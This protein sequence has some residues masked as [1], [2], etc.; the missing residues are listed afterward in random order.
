MDRLDPGPPLT[1]HSISPHT[2]A[3]TSRLDAER[4]KGEGQLVVSTRQSLPLVPLERRQHDTERDALRDYKAIARLLDAPRAYDLTPDIV[5][6]P[7]THLTSAHQRYAAQPALSFFVAWVCDTTPE[8]G[9]RCIHPHRTLVRS[10]HPPGTTI[11]GT[12]PLSSSPDACSLALAGAAHP[13]CVQRL[14]AFP[15]FP[16]VPIA[17]RHTTIAFSRI[18]PSPL[19]ACASVHPQPAVRDDRR[20]QRPPRPFLLAGVPLVASAL[21]ATSSA[22]SHSKPASATQQN[23]TRSL[24]VV[25]S[26]CSPGCQSPASPSSPHRILRRSSWYSDPDAPRFRLSRTADPMRITS[27]VCTTCDNPSPSLALRSAP[28]PMLRPFSPLQAPSI[29]CAAPSICTP[30]PFSHRRRLSYPCPRDDRLRHPKLDHNSPTR[31]SVLSARAALAQRAA[32]GSEEGQC[33]RPQHEIAA[34]TRSGEI[35]RSGRCSHCGHGEIISS[36]CRTLIVHSRRV[37][38]A[39]VLTRTVLPLRH[40]VVLPALAVRTSSTPAA[41]HPT[42]ASPTRH[43]RTPPTPYPPRPSA[44]F[45]PFAPGYIQR[46][47]LHGALHGGVEEEVVGGGCEGPEGLA[48]AEGRD[49]LDAVLVAH[50]LAWLLAEPEH[51]AQRR[52][53][54][55]LIAVPVPM[56]CTSKLVENCFDVER[57]RPPVIVDVAG[58][59]A[60]GDVADDEEAAEMA[61]KREWAEWLEKVVAHDRWTRWWVAGIF[62]SAQIKA[63]IGAAIV[64][65]VSAQRVLEH[66]GYEKENLLSVDF[67]F[68]A[69]ETFNAAQ[70]GESRSGPWRKIDSKGGDY[71]LERLATGPGVG[72]PA[73][74][75]L[76]SQIVDCNPDEGSLILSDGSVVQSDVVLGEDGISDASGPRNVIEF[77]NKFR[78]LFLYPCRDG[79]LMNFLAG[80][81]DPHQADP[82]WEPAGTREDLL[83]EFTDYHPQ[84][85]TLFTMLPERLP[86][87]QLHFRPTLSTWARDA[88]KLTDGLH[89]AIGQGAAQ[90]IE[91]AGTLSISSQLGRRAQ[92][93]PRLKAFEGL[94]KERAELIAR[95]SHDQMMVPSERGKYLR[96]PELQKV[97]MG[98]DVLDAARKVYAE[99]FGGGGI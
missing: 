92:T 80:V 60:G 90:A 62:E 38:V 89:I 28:L 65:P 55:L 10:R 50:D 25:C 24:S 93:Y 87:W 45:N 40:V 83:A 27:G 48:A 99:Q 19:G 85:Q 97:V 96:D 66:L 37:R 78:I 94:R 53:I 11:S 18:P 42:N 47:L 3:R 95:E 58:A 7:H 41:P 56:A 9:A 74:I 14:P 51:P 4:I 5:S 82:G 88:P 79:T 77:G 39:R 12:A 70:G 59:A 43:T 34:H 36:L 26:I 57:A 76:S 63:E 61:R 84:F 13:L 35:P 6:R 44:T 1:Q 86:R 23:T 20:A 8:R 72:P 54:L 16:V 67:D 22:P 31:T 46:V 49:A 68:V 52:T 98:Y 71:E 91:D 21:A 75:R 17:A 2:S 30:T 32:P 81:E 29:A 33:G 15:I 73:V 64:V 69:I